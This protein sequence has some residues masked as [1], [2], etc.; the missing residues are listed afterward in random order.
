MV[1]IAA[2]S[3]AWSVAIH[4]LSGDFYNGFIGAKLAFRERDFSEMDNKTKQIFENDLERIFQQSEA[5]AKA[6]TINTNDVKSTNSN[7]L[8]QADEREFNGFSLGE[9]F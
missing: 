1:L 5:A 8:M 2:S 6:Q 4:I 9:D 7:G 3:I